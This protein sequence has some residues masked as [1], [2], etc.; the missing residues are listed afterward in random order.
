[1]YATF[2]HALSRNRPDPL[3]EVDVR[4]AGGGCLCWA[5]HGVELPF[6][7]AARS[8]FYA[9]IGN[10]HHELFQLIGRK[11][12]HVFLF[13]LF[14]D[15]ANSTERIRVNQSRIDTIGHDLIEALG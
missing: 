9:G 13:G 11:G 15:G 12:R 7:K 8:P 1:M 2:L 4:P 10:C 5:G 6:D 14:E 3:L